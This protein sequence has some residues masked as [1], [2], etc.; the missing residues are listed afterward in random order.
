MY[1]RTVTIRYLLWSGHPLV[2]KLYTLQPSLVSNVCLI[3]ETWH[4]LRRGTETLPS[5]WRPN[6]SSMEELLAPCKSSWIKSWRASRPRLVTSQLGES[7]IWG[8]SAALIRR[9][10]PELQEKEDENLIL[11]EARLYKAMAIRFLDLLLEIGAASWVWSLLCFLKDEMTKCMVNS[12][13]DWIK[14]VT[15]N[16]F[17]QPGFCFHHSTF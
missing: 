2:A 14:Y 15:W 13:G 1:G 9:C 17:Q 11:A 12:W 3:V 4:Y 16:K 6:I 10:R 5:T 7:F 8:W